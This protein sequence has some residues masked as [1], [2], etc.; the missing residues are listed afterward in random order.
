MEGRRGRGSGGWAPPLRVPLPS[1]CF[2]L[3]KTPTLPRTSL[4]SAHSCGAQSPQ[5]TSSLPANHQDSPW[6]GEIFAERAPKDSW[7]PPA[8]PSDPHLSFFMKE[9]P[10][11][12]LISALHSRPQ[13]SSGRQPRADS[14][15]T[16]WSQRGAPRPASCPA[17]LC[18]PQ[19]ASVQRA[20]AAARSPR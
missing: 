3:V 10:D 6:Q 15:R 20:G 1:R 13:E 14:E 5:S 17:C 12:V 4:A 7:K 18:P 2:C 8:F 16:L 19:P 11:L 9:V